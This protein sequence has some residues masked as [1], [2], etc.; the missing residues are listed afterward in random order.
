MCGS[1]LDEGYA[2]VCMEE[3]AVQGSRKRDGGGETCVVGTRVPRNVVQSD[4]CVT[5]TLTLA[6]RDG[7]D[8]RKE[9]RRCA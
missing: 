3:V 8:G 5:L 4:P 6:R 1:A 9:V 2:E 7:K